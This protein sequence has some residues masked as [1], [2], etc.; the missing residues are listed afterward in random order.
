M[1]WLCFKPIH[2]PQI[3]VN[4]LFFVLTYFC[5]VLLLVF[6]P[7]KNTYPRFEFLCNNR[8]WT[9]IFLSL[10]C[11]FNNLFFLSKSRFKFLTLLPKARLRWW[12]LRYSSVW[13]RSCFSDSLYTHNYWFLSSL[14]ISFVLISSLRFMSSILF[15]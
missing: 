15:F 12:T 13:S 4:Q 8:L 10:F 2:P 14:C 3:V 11:F 9:F 5:L 7:N 1:L 6:I